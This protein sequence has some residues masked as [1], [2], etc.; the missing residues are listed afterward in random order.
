MKS[1][2]QM[3]AH[4]NKIL[5]NELVAIN[6]YFLHAKMQQD[7]GLEKLAAKTREESIDEMKH[8]E[9]LTDRILFLDGLP[10]FQDLGRLRIGQTV[11]EMLKADFE[12]ELDAISDLESA[13]AYAESIKDFGSRDLLQAILVSEEAHQDFLDKQLKL[14]KQVGLE[15]YLQSQ[16]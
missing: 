13:I 5:K 8:A 14:I 9:I 7:V 15:N 12:L 6:Q 10:N 11:E 4:L 1:D 2:K 3:I 16:I